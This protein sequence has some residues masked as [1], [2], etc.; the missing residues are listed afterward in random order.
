M[1]SIQCQRPVDHTK[2]IT[3]QNHAPVN[4]YGYQKPADHTKY[5]HQHAPT[6]AQNKCNNTCTCCRRKE[7]EY[8]YINKVKDMANSAYK[9]VAEQIHHHDQHNNGHRP[10]TGPKPVSP[11]QKDGSMTN[12]IPRIGD[13][14][15]RD[16]TSR[17]KKGNDCKRKDGSSSSD[18]ESDNE[19]HVKR[20]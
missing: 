1:A 9:K 4:T 18:S 2:N 11:K 6:N 13:H 17:K 10:N 5:N 7:N 20:T 15:K 19:A 14:K 3:Q 16:K 12:C 8:S